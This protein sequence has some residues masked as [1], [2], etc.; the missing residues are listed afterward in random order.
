M[1]EIGTATVVD[2][3]VVGMPGSV[4]RDAHIA[5]SNQK[6]TTK[7]RPM[8]DENHSRLRCILKLALMASGSERGVDA[9]SS[10]GGHRPVVWPYIEAA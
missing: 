3:G 2:V 6:P 4:V 9:N 5:S 1:D 10:L 8:A 7:T